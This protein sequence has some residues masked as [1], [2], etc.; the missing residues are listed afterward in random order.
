[1]LSA[2]TEK[3]ANP[4]DRANTGGTCHRVPRRRLSDGAKAIH[5]RLKLGPIT[6]ADA[7]EWTCSATQLR[8]WIDELIAAAKPITRDLDRLGSPVY[9]LTAKLPTKKRQ[10]RKDLLP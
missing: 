10:P 9:T 8:T 2:T 6:L 5:R 1:M 7:I 4:V 3:R